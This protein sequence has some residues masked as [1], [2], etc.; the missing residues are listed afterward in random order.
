ME[1][2]LDI[3]L[4]DEK[5]EGPSS[6]LSFLGIELDSLFFTSGLL[7]EKLSVLR[8]LLLYWCDK[9]CVPSLGAGVSTRPPPPCSQSCLPR[10]PLPA[11]TYRPPV[12]S[13]SSD[14]GF[15]ADL[16]WWL[17]FVKG[18]EWSDLLHLPSAAELFSMVCGWFIT[19]CPLSAL[20][21]LLLKSCFG[22][23]LQPMCGVITG[24]A[25]ASSSCA[26]TLG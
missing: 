26:R 7:T 25:F 21:A 13:A 23:L 24:L 3:P 11:P 2:H 1:V 19:G 20:P 6:C 9:R 5:V 15:Q 4:V 10:L 16:R 18:L 8:D 14:T 17:T 12:W 22:S